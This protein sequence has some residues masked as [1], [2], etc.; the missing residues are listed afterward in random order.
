MLF[1]KIKNLFLKIK[2]YSVELVLK[3][4]SGP[5]IPSTSDE[6][7]R[8]LPNDDHVN[9]EEEFIYCC[10]KCTTEDIENQRLATP[11]KIVISFNAW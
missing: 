10:G 4:F 6:R 1:S 8:I 11:A 2:K 3:C 9:T 7:E 5:D